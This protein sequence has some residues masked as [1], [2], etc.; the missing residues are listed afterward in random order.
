MSFIEFKNICK[1]YP[2]SDK[3]TVD[4]FNLN[5]EEKEFIAFVGP[6]GC[7][8]STTLRM[9]AGFEEITGGELCIDGRKV[10]EVAPRDRGIAM[11]FQNYALYP[12]MTV[13]KNIG[14]GLKNMKMPADQ[15]K[16]KVDW[17]ID[18]LGLEEY[19][20]RKPKNLSGGQR[21]RVALGRAIVKNQKVFLM[22]EPLSNL[23]AK[24]RVSM[25]TEISKL[26]RELGATTIDVT[27]D[28]VEGTA[29]ADRIVIMKD[30][31]IQ[32]VGKPMELYD[33]PKNQ[34]VAGFIG[35]PQMNFFNV[36]VSGNTVKF[37]DGN[38]LTLSEGME[39]KLNGRQ[40]EMVMGIRG[41][42]IKMDAQNMDL[43]SAN[44]QHAVITDTEVMGNENNLYFDFGGTQA[45]ARVSKYEISQIG[46]QINFVFMPS[47]MHFF[48]KETGINY[49]EEV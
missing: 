33:H 9:I 45:V 37:S 49:T 15:I 13:E 7:G 36:T 12:H 26:H 38:A 41:E 48:D 31:V 40:G 39:K 3:N 43:N 47:K 8:K 23:D 10:N 16:K 28:Q 46:D 44:R 22:D 29:M 42:D 6:S 32:Q 11:V 21:Q 25:R 19:R 24:L 20:Y 2:G 14:Y 17:A 34:F 4:N 30:G 35:S 5:I 27:R 1:M 18:I